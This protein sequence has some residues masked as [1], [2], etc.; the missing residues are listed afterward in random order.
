MPMTPKM[1]PSLMVAEAL[2]SATTLPLF[3]VNT[4]PKFLISIM[5]FLLTP[6]R[7]WPKGQTKKPPSLHDSKD[8]SL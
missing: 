7:Y 8:E 3:S 5:F 2:R 6:T 4:L 1:S